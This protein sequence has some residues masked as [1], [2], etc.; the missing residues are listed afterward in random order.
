MY[1]KLCTLP[2]CVRAAGQNRRF[3]RYKISN[4]VIRR[5]PKYIRFLEMLES[6]GAVRVSS[7]ELGELMG[8][9]ASQIRQDFNC[10]GGFGQ[11]GYGY[12]V[13]QLRE[14]M[15]EIMGIDTEHTAIVIGA[16][17]LGKAIIAN[18]KF[19]K[20]GYKLLAAFDVCPD[21]VG[22]TLNDTPVYHVDK[23]EEYILTNKVD[24]AALT[25]PGEYAAATV[26]RL[27]KCGVP[28][29][30]NF[31]RLEFPPEHN[32]SKIENVHLADSLLVLS[33]ALKPKTSEETE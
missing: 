11:Q 19:K 27:T 21:V 33:Y 10:F 14:A 6:S 12:N 31:T 3:M 29:I 5:L 15:A 8:L 1:D 18:F 16:G 23:L 13:Q 30:W 28:G 22:K 32:G 7:Q 20:F 9:T 17:N 25:L 26:T 2:A 4:N 24:V